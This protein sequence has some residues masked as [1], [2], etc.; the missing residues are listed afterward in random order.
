MLPRLNKN[1]KFLQPTGNLEISIIIKNLENKLGGVDKVNANIFKCLQQHITPILE[2]IFNI[3]IHKSIWPSTLKVAE[4][5]ACLSTKMQIKH[6]CL[7]T[8]L[9]FLKFC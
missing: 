7:Q 1:S 6:L 3:C 2:N 4:V 8:Y 9:S 5:V